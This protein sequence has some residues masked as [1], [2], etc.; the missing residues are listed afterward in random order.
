MQ[1]LA[2]YI[3]NQVEKNILVQ[4]SPYVVNAGP[5]RV[6]QRVMQVVFYLDSEMNVL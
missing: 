4:R 5:A 1:P 2:V 6:L 3:L